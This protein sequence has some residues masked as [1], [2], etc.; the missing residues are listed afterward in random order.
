MRR[1]TTGHE[2]A[3]PLPTLI[4]EYALSLRQPWA[5]LLVHGLKT[6]EVRSWPTARRGRVY[7]HAAR[8]PDER[9]AAWKRVPAALRAETGL[10]GGI[11]GVGVLTQCRCYRNL[12]AF[13]ADRTK[14]LNDPEWFHPPVLYGF[15]FKYARP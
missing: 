12:D 3:A 13:A 9:T 6:I 5:A 7:I 15:E 2:S 1:R 10:R 8:L 11:V 4:A 14:H